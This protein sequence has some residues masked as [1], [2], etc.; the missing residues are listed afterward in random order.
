MHP[1]IHLLKSIYLYIHPWIS[2]HLNSLN[3]KFWNFGILK[4][5]HFS[6]IL[7]VAHPWYSGNNLTLATASLS[8]NSLSRP[9]WT[10]SILHC[11]IQGKFSTIKWNLVKYY[12][13]VWKYVHY[14]TIRTLCKTLLISKAF[15]KWKNLIKSNI[16]GHNNQSHSCLCFTTFLGQKA[17]LPLSLNRLFIIQSIH[18]SW[19]YII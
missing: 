19:S 16:T 13:N 6:A 11:Q 8:M 12:V 2:S 9:V 5:S 10:N 14:V 18:F 15:T 4:Q 1:Y 17:L 3:R 7:N